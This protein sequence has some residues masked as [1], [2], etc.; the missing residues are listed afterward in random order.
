MNNEDVLAR[1]RD[2]VRADRADDV[3]LEAVARG[4]RGDKVV[5]LGRRA[6]GDADLAAMIEASRSSDKP[7]RSIGGCVSG[8]S[9]LPCHCA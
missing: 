3:A 5:E 8:M 4:E 1:I 6:L 2:H 7:A 9:P